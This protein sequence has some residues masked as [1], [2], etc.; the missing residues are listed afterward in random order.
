MKGT[1]TQAP[2]SRLGA[3]QSDARLRIT[4]GHR[5]TPDLTEDDDAGYYPTR[6]THAP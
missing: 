5:A 1:A 4:D 2:A 6:G 3:V